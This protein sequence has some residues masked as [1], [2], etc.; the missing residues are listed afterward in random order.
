[1]SKPAPEPTWLTQEAF[2]RLQADLDDRMGRL[3]TEIT[4]RI[5]A[6]REEGDLK[7]NGGYH[8]AKEEQGKNEARIRQLRHMLEN[9]VVGTPEHD[10]TVKAGLLVTIRFAGDDDTETFLLG[11][12]EEAAHASVDV[13]SVK[14]PLGEAVMGLSVG[15]TGTFTAPNGRQM[16]V[17]IVAVDPYVP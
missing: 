5:E 9:S 4:M 6:A 14:S 2:D 16:S 17:E 1:V 7:E 12:R 8:A 15:D 13:Y 11:S 3:R 10:G